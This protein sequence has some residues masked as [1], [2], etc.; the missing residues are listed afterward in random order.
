MSEAR[1][2]ALVRSYPHPRALARRVRDVFP[3]LRRLEARGL[4]TQRRGLYRL[5]DR[6]RRELAM[7]EA[8]WR[9]VARSYLASR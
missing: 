8:L 7:T 5:T 3:G 2:L 4:V 9:L 1:L 6:G